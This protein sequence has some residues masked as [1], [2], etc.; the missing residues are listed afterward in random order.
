MPPIFAQHVEPATYRTTPRTTADEKQSRGLWELERWSDAWP[1][2]VPSLRRVWCLH[3]AES[4]LNLYAARTR[5]DKGQRWATSA[6][7]HAPSS[8]GASLIW[9]LWRRW[10]RK[11]EH[12]P[13]HVREEIA[14]NTSRGALMESVQQEERLENHR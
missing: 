11:L 1:S 12:M 2:V 4:S 13:Q 14:V 10:R 9:H 7:H 3:S 6:V 5:R 8:Y